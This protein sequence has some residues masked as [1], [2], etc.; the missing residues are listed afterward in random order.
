MVDTKIILWSIH[1]GPFKL[2]N[3]KHKHRT[4]CQLFVNSLSLSFLVYW[5]EINNSHAKLVQFSSLISSHD[6]FCRLIKKI[7]YTNIFKILLHVFLT[8][9]K[10]QS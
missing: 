3:H 9:L 6:M 5:I 1:R 7:F 8:N 2:M 4:E 10:R